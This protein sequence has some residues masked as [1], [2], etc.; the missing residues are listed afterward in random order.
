[1]TPQT[2]AS[3]RDA[4]LIFLAAIVL[5]LAYNSMSPLGV[6]TEST[7]A[8]LA[9]PPG[10]VSVPAIGVENETLSI[11]IESS[12]ATATNGPSVPNSVTWPQAQALLGKGALLVDVR[13]PEAY[14]AGHITGAIS[15]PMNTLES[16]IA[17][18][19][20]R[21]PSDK[22]IIAYCASSQC[23][24]ARTAAQLL[25]ERHGFTDVREM[26]GGYAEWRL[27]DYATRALQK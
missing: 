16:E 19:K 17:T 21:F 13:E 2:A 22:I 6:R 8:P 26:P 1:M 11:T 10:P 18:F 24:I 3:L 5:G 23:A 25:M 9:P 14:T 15:L 27:A 20:A 4:A 7:P 12:P